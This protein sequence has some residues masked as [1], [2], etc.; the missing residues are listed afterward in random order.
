MAPAEYRSSASEF[1]SIPTTRIDDVRE[2]LRAAF[3]AKT[4]GTMQPISGGVSG[5]TIL[6]FEV[7]SRPYVLRL[8]PERIALHHRERHFACMTSAAEAG[9]APRV[10]F[11]D[12]TRGVSIMDCIATRPLAEY[13][14]GPAGLAHGLGALVAR[15][16]NS[17]TFPEMGDF[18]QVIGAMLA[19]LRASGLFAAHALDRH[20]E[21][22][23]RIQAQLPWDSASLVSTHND[24]N[25]RNILFDGNRLWLIDWELASRNDPLVDIAILS[26]ELAE[27]PALQE[28]LLSTVFGKPANREMRARLAIIRLLTRLFYGCIVL[29]NFMN[30]PRTAPDSN[31]DEYSPVSF[32]AAIADGRLAS[33]SQEVAYAFGKMSL[34]AFAAGI[35]APDFTELLKAAA[36]A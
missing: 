2:A 26:T 19:A 33:G 8:E 27:A 13:P 32:R 5:A 9:A 20:A 30:L 29:E 12:A 23:A 35:A 11:A 1:P 3:G 18:P 24:P 14:G 36:Q 28:T 6:R 7:D 16:Q 15:V 21:G 25:P 17:R 31:P 22:L 10:Y 4:I 34:T